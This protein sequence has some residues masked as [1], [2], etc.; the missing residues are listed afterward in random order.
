MRNVLIAILVF[1]QPAWSH[2]QA[3]TNLQT[4]Q[5]LPSAPLPQALNQVPPTMPP[6][7]QQL[8]DPQGTLGVQVSLSLQQA[9]ALALKNNPQ[10]SAARLT[11]LASQQVTREVRSNL[12]PTAIADLTAVDANPGSRITAG[13]LN[14][15]VVYQRA[16]AGVV[17][18]QLR[19]VSA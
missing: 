10:I 6:N 3:A 17:V 9:E 16:A 2:A 1:L 12:W 14:N 19:W 11:A 15:P 4:A 18:N 8:S 5:S 7:G 13:G